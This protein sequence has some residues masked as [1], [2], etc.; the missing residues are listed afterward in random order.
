MRIFTKIANDAKI[1][2]MLKSGGANEDKALTMLYKQNKKIIVN[3]ILKNSGTREAACDLFQDALIIFCEQV[4]NDKFVLHE[5][6]KISTYIFMIAKR[7]WINELKRKGLYLKYE[8]T[9]SN[10]ND[11]MPETPLNRVLTEERQNIINQLMEQ[12]GEDCKQILLMTIYEG[13]SM[14]E[15]A[16]K[17]GYKNVDVAKNKKYKCKERLKTLVENSPQLSTKLKEIISL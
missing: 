9:L 1:I 13:L 8:N 10:E 3:H 7:L 6:T 17:M 4:R 5:N 15:V 14:T 12:L 2:E 16:E 11:L